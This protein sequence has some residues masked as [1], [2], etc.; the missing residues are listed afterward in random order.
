M[1]FIARCLFALSILHMQQLLST[2]F[3]LA[4]Q[5]HN[6]LP[7]KLMSSFQLNPEFSS[8]IGCI[9]H[10]E[11]KE[12]ISFR[13]KGDIDTPISLISSIDLNLTKIPLLLTSNGISI[14][15][16]D[17]DTLLATWDELQDIA[18]KG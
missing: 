12:I 10:H 18:D 16:T 4:K 11:A 14:H 13:P 6:F 9:S 5:S 8:W 17:G 3:Q 15:S 7:S 2:S 1:N